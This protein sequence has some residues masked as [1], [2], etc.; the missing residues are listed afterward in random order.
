MSNSKI[1]LKEG[2]VKLYYKNNKIIKEYR[3]IR[4][5][6]IRKKDTIKKEKSLD[7]EFSET[8]LK[9]RQRWEAYNEEKGYEVNYDYYYDKNE[10]ESEPDV[11]EEEEDMNDDLIGDIYG[12]D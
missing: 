4:K 3:P 6:F 9:M 10:Y 7:Q 5:S 2:W 11:D 8:I 12:E 1:E